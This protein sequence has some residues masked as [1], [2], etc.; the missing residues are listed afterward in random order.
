MSDVLTSIIEGVLEDLDRR[1]IPMSQLQAQLRD[2]G[3]LRGAKA[4]L[5]GTD[6][7]IISEVKRASPSK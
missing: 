1:S 6:M 4:A 7:K 5:T 3:Q 2:A